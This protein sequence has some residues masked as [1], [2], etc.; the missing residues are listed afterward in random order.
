MLKYM[1]TWGR[2][3]KPPTRTSIGR[4]T[5]TQSAIGMTVT[6]GFSLTTAENEG[7]KTADNNTRLVRY[8]ATNSLKW[9]PNNIMPTLLSNHDVKTK[10]SPFLLDNSNTPRGAKR[11]ITLDRNFDKFAWM[12]NR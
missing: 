9:T 8:T 2:G 7:F 3:I 5:A 6:D 4:Q 11:A 1:R 12:Y 10:E